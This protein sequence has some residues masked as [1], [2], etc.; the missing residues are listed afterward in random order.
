M[1]S[2]STQEQNLRWEIGWLHYVEAHVLTEA[3]CLAMI[4]GEAPPGDESYTPIDQLRAELERI[5]GSIDIV[6][7]YAGIHDDIEDMLLELLEL[8]RPT[9]LRRRVESLTVEWIRWLVNAGRAPAAV[10]AAANIVEPRHS[11]RHEPS[12]EDAE[13][14]F[15]NTIRHEPSTEDAEPAFS[16]DLTLDSEEEEAKRRF[17]ADTDND[18]DDDD[19]DDDGSVRIG[20]LLCYYCSSR[21]RSL[22]LTTRHAR[23]TPS[24]NSAT[25]EHPH[26]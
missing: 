10:S 22:N 24:T 3:E 15:S 20:Y 1:A 23:F 5:Y 19:D 17:F 4:R 12:T 9:P 25:A 21:S 6:P 16:D 11:I 26:R 14:A 18:D 2:N 13:P 8:A 7:P